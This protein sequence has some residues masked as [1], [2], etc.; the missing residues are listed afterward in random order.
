MPAGMQST[1]RKRWVAIAPRS[2]SQTVRPVTY[3][4]LPIPL[5]YMFFVRKLAVDENPVNSVKFRLSIL[6]AQCLFAFMF[7]VSPYEQQSYIA[8]LRHGMGI[9]AFSG[10]FYVDIS[11]F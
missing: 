11:F 6:L 3:F 2:L 10:V 8:A 4:F 9:R 7:A 1:L 5:Y